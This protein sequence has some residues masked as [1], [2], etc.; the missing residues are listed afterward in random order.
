MAW[1]E[2]LKVLGLIVTVCS[3]LAAPFVYI[4][5]NSEKEK[6]NKENDIKKFKEDTNKELKELRERTHTHD[7]KVAGLEQGKVGH[8]QMQEA[9]QR[10]ETSTNNQIVA[11]NNK[12]DKNHNQYRQELN[13]CMSDLKGYIK[14]MIPRN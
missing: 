14:D 5:K 12:I 6:E 7:V 1:V 4:W 10:L 8:E 2:W 11:L 3:A 13:D 9:I